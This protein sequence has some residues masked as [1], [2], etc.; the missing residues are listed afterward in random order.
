[1]ARARFRVA[2]ITESFMG[3]QFIFSDYGG[4]GPAFY[5]LVGPRCHIL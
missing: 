4:F 2:T 1:M 5:D 3:W